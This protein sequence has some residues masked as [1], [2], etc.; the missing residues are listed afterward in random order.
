MVEATRI[1]YPDTTKKTDRTYYMTSRQPLTLDDRNGGRVLYRVHL[2]D[3]V[4]AN[5][6][7]RLKERDLAV[8]KPLHEA[9]KSLLDMDFS[10]EQVSARTGVR[11]ARVGAPRRPRDEDFHGN[12]LPEHVRAGPW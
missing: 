5:V 9:V 4:A 1:E 11:S 2:A 6:R 8:N 7:A 12:G 3:L 10:P